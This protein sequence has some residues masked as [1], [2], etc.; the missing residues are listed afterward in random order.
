MAT[1]PE[2]LCYLC[3][4]PFQQ[5]FEMVTNMRFDE[6]PNYSKLI[7]LFDGSIGHNA[8]LRPIRTD[9]ATKVVAFLLLISLKCL[10]S[11]LTNLKPSYCIG[12]SEK[13]KNACRFR[14]W[15]AT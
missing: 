11:F 7:S 3:P 5:F 15:R 4:P 8:S 14:R 10:W 13:G 9:G 1:S 6:E 12:G 2:M